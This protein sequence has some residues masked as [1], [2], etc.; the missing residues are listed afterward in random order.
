[1]ST[2]IIKSPRTSLW[3]YLF[4]VSYHKRCFLII[5]VIT[6]CLL[7]H[8]NTSQHFKFQTTEY[9]HKLEKV[10]KF[11]GDVHH[12][13]IFEDTLDD[14]LDWI[15]ECLARLFIHSRIF[16]CSRFFGNVLIRFEKCPGG[17]GLRKR[18]NRTKL[19]RQRAKMNRFKSLYRRPRTLRWTCS[20]YW[21]DVSLVGVVVAVDAAVLVVGVVAVVSLS[22]LQCVVIFIL[23]WS[24]H[25]R[26]TYFL[27]W[28]CSIFFYG[29]NKVP[30]L[31]LHRII[32]IHFYFRPVQKNKLKKI[33]T[34]KTHFFLRWAECL[35]G[36]HKSSKSCLWLDPQPR[37]RYILCKKVSLR[38][39]M[40]RLWKV[41]TSLR[42][43]LNNQHWT[44]DFDWL[45]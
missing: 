16:L 14:Q 12:I 5:L 45:F 34:G 33:R 20:Q 43:S 44:R 42:K 39:R 8:L 31:S 2:R 25:C 4:E 30:L 23:L 38:K 24:E 7:R 40:R 36:F 21:F 13:K 27:S 9:G 32:V 3:T 6:R 26:L 10:C 15:D 37:Q 29:G 1:M 11:F 28:K 22:N 35:R 18:K 17:C 19:S 41:L